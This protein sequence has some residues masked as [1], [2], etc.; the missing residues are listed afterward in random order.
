MKNKL[1]FLTVVSV[2]LAFFSINASALENVAIIDIDKISKEAKVVKYIAKEISNK[3]DIYQKEI[4]SKEKKLEDERKKIE[5]KK[6]I[7]SEEALENQQKKF[8]EEV[9]DLKEFAAKRD[10]T[11]KDAY[12][13][14]INKVNEKVGEIVSEIAKKQNLALVLPSSQVVY[15]TDNLEITDEVI[16]ELDKKMSKTKVAFK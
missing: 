13:E 7:L 11:L 15:S 6:N 14:A 1:K 5:A 2:I 3:R 9:K 10:K 8:I 16:K 4:S 12:S